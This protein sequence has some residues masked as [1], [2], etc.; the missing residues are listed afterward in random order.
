MA[1]KADARCPYSKPLRCYQ[2]HESRSAIQ[3]LQIALEKR[4]GSRRRKSLPF[5]GSARPRV[6]HPKR[7]FVVALRVGYHEPHPS[8]LLLLFFLLSFPEGICFCSCSRFCSLVVIPGGNLLFL[9]PPQTP[10]PH[11]RRVNVF[12]NRVN[13]AA[14]PPAIPN[15]LRRCRPRGRRDGIVKSRPPPDRDHRTGHLKGA[16]SAIGGYRQASQP[17]KEGFLHALFP[18]RSRFYFIERK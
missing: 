11:P 18:L 6:P 4:A 16:R 10:D 1:G 17:P 2:P 14:T 12:G 7:V 5:L 9:N 3:P 13:T 8:L 15:P